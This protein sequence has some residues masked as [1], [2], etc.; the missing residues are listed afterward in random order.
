M[1]AYLATSKYPGLAIMNPASQLQCSSRAEWC[2]QTG[3]AAKT[4]SPHY[5]LGC[6]F[7]T[8]VIILWKEG[9]GEPIY[10][11][12]SHAKQLGRSRE[13]LQDARIVT[14]PSVQRD[15]P[16]QREDSAEPQP[17]VDS[18]PHQASK[19]EKA[20]EPE[21]VSKS[22]NDS[23]SE[24]SPLPEAPRAVADAKPEPPTVEVRNKPSVRDL[25]YGSSA[26]AMVDEAIWNMAAG[27][28]QAYKAALS[29]G[30]SPCEAAEAAGGQLAF[31]HRKLNEYTLKLENIL[32]ASQATINV[33]DTIDKPLEQ[34]I[35]DVINNDATN[36]SEKDAAT[37]QLGNLQESVKRGLQRELTPLQ[38]HRILLAI[39]DRSDWGR[40]A[41]LSEN[42]KAACRALFV[43]LR[44]ALCS[45]VPEA[46]NLH[47][48]LINLYAAKSEMEAR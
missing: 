2:L 3:K 31:I 17:V 40:N 9:G 39:G 23:K 12:D 35:S 13:H 20:N 27:N 7:G 15:R 33:A 14:P 21:N 1:S 22:A 4:L 46:Q 6:D 38:A 47:D 32:S 44:A 8:P 34:V 41:G 29:Q 30:K 24:K 18:R 5:R 42:F 25:T 26:K 28:Y 19:S 10:V 48:R 16:A 37:E 11:C 36:D 43:G 45:A